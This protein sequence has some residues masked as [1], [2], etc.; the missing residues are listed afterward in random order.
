MD[1]EEDDNEVTASHPPVES[2]VISHKNAKI[3]ASPFKVP[4]SNDKK[5]VELNNYTNQS[6]IVIGK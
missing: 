3:T 2:I 5:L 4:E 1:D 6:L